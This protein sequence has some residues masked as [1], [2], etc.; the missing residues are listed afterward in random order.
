MIQQAANE[1]GIPSPFSLFGNVDDDALQLIALANR[2]VKEFSSIANKNGG[3]QDLHNEYTF[4]TEFLDTTGDYTANSPVITNIPSTAS[5]VAGDWG[6]SSSPFQSG[7]YILSVDSSTQVTLSNPALS[8]GTGQQIIF[9]K[10]AYALPSDFEYFVQKT[11]WDNRF[12]WELIGPI[13]AQEKQILRYGVIASG[14]RNKFYIRK[15]KMWLDPVPSAAFMIAYDYY[16][17]APVLTAS[18]ALS[19][20]W[21]TDSDTYLLDEDVFIQGIKWR[22]L[23]AKGLDYAEEYDS[24]MM[25]TQRTIARDGGSRDLP[26][27]EASYGQHFLDGGNVPET[28]YGNQ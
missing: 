20:V 16:S 7:T 24:Y 14:P 3:W 28:G 22:F 2:E 1:I 10:V 25:D 11:F 21:T 4:N 12:K 5:L 8:S 6:V 13:T 23:R 9:G 17:N 26:I 18:S 19:S 27:G 15:N